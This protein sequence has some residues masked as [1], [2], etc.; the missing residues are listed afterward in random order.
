MLQHHE[1]I[2]NP[3]FSKLQPPM[4]LKPASLVLEAMAIDLMTL[5]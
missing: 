2:Y 5:P 1:T 3:I 4:G